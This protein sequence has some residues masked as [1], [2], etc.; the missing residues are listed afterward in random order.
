LH[1]IVHERAV[2]LG[3]WAHCKANATVRA[4]TLQPVTT[5]ARRVLKPCFMARIVPWA[6]RL[7]GGLFGKAKR[8]RRT[9]LRTLHTSP[10]KAC[11]A[12]VNRAVRSHRE[13]SNQEKDA[14]H[15]PIL[16]R[17]DPVEP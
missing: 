13:V 9:R 7:P 15:R 10:A 3:E 12:S 2:F 4:R 11:Y 8:T 1:K 17:D 6:S 14:H 5:A 16:W